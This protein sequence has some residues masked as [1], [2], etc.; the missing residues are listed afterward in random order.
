MKGSSRARPVRAG[1]RVP[2]QRGVPLTEELLDA[3][4]EE[5]E[6]GF[7]PEQ[8]RGPGRPRLGPADGDGPSS[9]VQ[10]RLDDGLRRRL[11]ERAEQDAVTVS[12][13]VRAALRA[14]LT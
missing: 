8:F 10:V 13:V 4:V 5:A 9:V 12:E 3:V 14:H 1:A 7:G 2:R 6:A 11:G